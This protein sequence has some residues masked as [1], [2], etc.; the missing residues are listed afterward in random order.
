MFPL[1]SV[2]VNVTTFVAP[3]FVQSNAVLLMLNVLIPQLSVDPSFTSDAANVA[4]PIAFKVN[5]TFLAFAVGAA[6]SCTVTVEKSV[7]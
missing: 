5:V 1:L 7:A 3:M 2:T 6:T 4:A